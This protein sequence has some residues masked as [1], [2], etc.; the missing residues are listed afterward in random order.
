MVDEREDAYLREPFNLKWFLMQELSAWYVFL[1]GTVIGALLFGGGYFLVKVVLPSA[2]DYQAE[3]VYYLE[4]TE[5]PYDQDPSLTDPYFYFNEYTLNQWI[6]SDFFLETVNR[7]VEKPLSELELADYVTVIL[8][9]DVRMQTL[10][11]VT[12]DPKLTNDLT[13]A[14]LEA[15]P[16]FGEQQREYL[17]IRA[18]DI[19]EQAYLVKADVRTARAVLLGAVLGLFFTFMVRTLL[20]L[21]DTRVWLPEQLSGRYGLKVLGCDCLPELKE[22]V[23]YLCRDKKQVGVTG[24]DDTPNLARVCETL[25]A[26]D[27]TTEFIPI[28][29]FE[30]AP[31]GAASLRQ[32]DGVL[33]AVSWG[34]V[35]GSLISRLLANLQTQD[36]PVDGA[37]LWDADEKT[38]NR[39]YFGTSENGFSKEK[40]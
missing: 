13:V 10:R 24:V 26:L 27:D 19:P 18:V 25:T 9:A 23:A 32:M 34:T 5:N 11:V 12:S 8:P 22:N 38:L 1:L 29:S 4:Y 17:S 6:H 31:E 30:Q 2:R 39:Y 21:M 28:P 7:Y 16:K 14:Y 40:Q 37:I 33:L 15:L 3:T 35:S 20:F 36:V